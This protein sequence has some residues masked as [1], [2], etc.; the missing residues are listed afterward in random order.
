MPKKFND[1][2]RRELDEIV[3]NVYIIEQYKERKL[4]LVEALELMRETHSPDIYDEP[5]ALVEAKLELSLRTKKKTKFLQNL[6]GVIAYPHLFPFSVK[7][8]VIA[9]CKTD[10]QQSEAR[11]AGA[12]LVGSSDIVRMLKVGDLTIDNFD[13]IVCH[14]DMYPEVFTI[15][16]VLGFSIPT[17]Q[18]G[19]VGTDMA[20]MVNY[21]VNGIEFKLVKDHMEPDYGFLQAPFGR[22][23]QSDEQLKDN[24]ARLLKVIDSNQPEGAPCEFITRALLYSEPSPEKFAVTFW[25]HID[26]YED[27][28]AQDDDEE[29]VVDGGDD[30]VQAQNK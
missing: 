20:Y 23:T 16:T 4:S 14:E 10:E 27:P 24:F 5:D 22:L 30:A 13:D 8:K 26:G 29:E 28:Y 2:D 17:K 6:S 1:D 18:R 19:N 21:F 7:R 15:R 9:I 11:E 3:D 12:E 25:Q